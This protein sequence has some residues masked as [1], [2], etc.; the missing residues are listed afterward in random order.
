MNTTNDS[1]RSVRPEVNTDPW[2]SNIIRRQQ[3]YKPQQERKCIRTRTEL[4][5]LQL[6]QIT[7]KHY[8]II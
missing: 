2:W 4:F 7:T 1:E 3:L 8:R 6:S 5:L